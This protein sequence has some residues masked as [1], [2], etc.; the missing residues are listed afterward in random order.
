MAGYLSRRQFVDAIGTVDRGPDGTGT[1]SDVKLKELAQL[2][3]VDGNDRIT[4]WEFCEAFASAE[5]VDA[6]ETG[7][8]DTDGLRRQFSNAIVQGVAG[9]VY[10]NRG[11]LR[12]TWQDGDPDMDGLISADE[13]RAGLRHA[14]HAL[15]SPLKRSQLEALVDHAVRRA[16]AEVRE[17]LRVCIIEIACYSCIIGDFTLIDQPRLLPVR[18]LMLHA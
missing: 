5:D 17:G 15:Q 6:G 16:E 8:T 4:I 13:F 1:V 11:I 2:V 14:N 10:N 18:V 9:F 7:A 12:R 3:D